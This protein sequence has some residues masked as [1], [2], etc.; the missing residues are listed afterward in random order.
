MTDRPITIAV[1]FDGTL[2]ELEAPL[3]WRPHA[4]EF[5]L[6]AAAAGAQIW[7]H[8]RRCAPGADSAGEE[9]FWRTGAAPAE[10]VHG[11]G[12]Y[13]EMRA[14][15]ELEGVWDLLLPW[16]LPGKPDAQ[17]FYDD[18]AEP[19]D[20][21]VAAAELGV[22]LV[23]ADARAASPVGGTPGGRPA[24]AGAG[25]AAVSPQPPDPAGGLRLR[26]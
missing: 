13:A 20:W 6:G 12:L 8:S 11:W 21:L 2:V 14:F 18:R 10:L 16:T 1:D 4:K 17:L 26:P 9:D 15:L 3:R 7:L 24:I 22:T 23:H 25:P 5:V 19:P